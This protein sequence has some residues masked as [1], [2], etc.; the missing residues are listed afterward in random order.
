MKRKSKLLPLSAPPVLVV[1][2]GNASGRGRSTAASVQPRKKQEAPDGA[3][4]PI[5][6]RLLPLPRSHDCRWRVIT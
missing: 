4:G 3:A 5:T 2:L 1:A 6:S